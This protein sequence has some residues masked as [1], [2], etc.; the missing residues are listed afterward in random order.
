MKAY[1]M[2]THSFS[3]KEE[4]LRVASFAVL[5]FFL[6]SFFFKVLPLSLFPFM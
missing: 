5:F 6:F 3:Y 2:F 4:R 1:S